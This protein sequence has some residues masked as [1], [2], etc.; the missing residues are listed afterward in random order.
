MTSPDLPT[1]LEEKGGIAKLILS[2]DCLAS[3]RNSPKVCRTIG[4]TISTALPSL[5]HPCTPSSVSQTVLVAHSRNWKHGS[6]LPALTF[7][8]YEQCGAG[9]YPFSTNFA[10]RSVRDSSNVKLAVAIP[11]ARAAITIWTIN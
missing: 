10:F 11:F 4:G 5:M 3:A 2:A 6:H 8:P 7:T 1:I 9:A